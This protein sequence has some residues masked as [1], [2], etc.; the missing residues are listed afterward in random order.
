MEVTAYFWNQIRPHHLLPSTTCLVN[1][2]ARLKELNKNGRTLPNSPAYLAKIVKYHSLYRTLLALGL[3]DTIV[4]LVLRL[5][6]LNLVNIGKLKYV[7]YLNLLILTISLYLTRFKKHLI[8]I[9]YEQ[10]DVI[11]ILLFKLLLRKKSH[12]M[13]S[14]FYI[15]MFL[16]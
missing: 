16:I 13:F 7:T 8:L 2:L 11:G 12:I 15:K 9:Y 3:V 5:R 10:Y 4:F 14:H 6:F 1:K